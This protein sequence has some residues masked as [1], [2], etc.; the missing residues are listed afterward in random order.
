MTSL[1]DHERNELKTQHKRERDGRIRDR[2]KAVLL[3]DKG[4]STSAIAEALLLSDDAICNHIS[5]YKES[6]KLK[7]EN[8]GSISKLSLHQS[9]LLIEHLRV[10]TYL[11]VKDIIAYVQSTMNISYTTPGMRDWLKRNGFSYK[12]PAIVPGKASAEQ[13]QQWIDDYAQT[14][15]APGR[16]DLLYRRSASDTQRPTC[17]WV[18][19]DGSQKRDCC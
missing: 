18:D 7:P 8:G 1:S 14:K 13:Q 11:Y 4:W 16:N 19:R 12:K 9:Q 15:Y 17:L 5:E 6:K 2:I 3:N 10:H